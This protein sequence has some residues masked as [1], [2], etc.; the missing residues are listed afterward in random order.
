[1]SQHS[2]RH[3]GQAAMAQALHFLFQIT[4]VT[5]QAG[6]EIVKQLEAGLKDID[7]VCLRRLQVVEISRGDIPEAVDVDVEWSAQAADEASSN[8]ECTE[9]A[10]C[11][12][13][14]GSSAATPCPLREML[15][16]PLIQ[17]KA[18]GLQKC[19]SLVGQL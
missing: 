12:H 6:A 18:A 15:A 11:S 3:W 9:G 8:G 2:G 14:S 4:V 1:M 17:G 7:L 5:S 10:G 19:T 16:P 13:S